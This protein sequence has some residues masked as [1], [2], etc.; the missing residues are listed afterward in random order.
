MA[1]ARAA[2]TTTKPSTP[3]QR[4]DEE[5]E[6]ATTND[7]QPP[8][9]VAEDHHLQADATRT[10][11]EESESDEP[12]SE[13][14]EDE[15]DANRSQ[16]SEETGEEPEEEIA[17]VPSPVNETAAQ[18][19]EDPNEEA[20]KEKKKERTSSNE[21]RGRRRSERTVWGSPSRARRDPEARPQ[22]CSNYLSKPAERTA[23][24]APFGCKLREPTQHA[25]S[26]VGNTSSAA[27]AA[28]KDSTS[29]GE[30]QRTQGCQD[31]GYVAGHATEGST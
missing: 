18:G 31:P 22:Q 8:T 25:Q 5:M 30:A 2:P 1:P 23:T 17:G 24:C 4:V 11:T 7:Q 10:A 9:E 27:C 13:P 29:I 26:V 3:K 6:A 15:E 12:T 16:A 14:S 19:Q 28:K 21:P 20:Q